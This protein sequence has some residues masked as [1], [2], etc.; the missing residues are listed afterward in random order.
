[1]SESREGGI[2]EG[3]GGA[4][5]KKIKSNEGITCKERGEGDGEGRPFMVPCVTSGFML[6]ARF[7]EGQRRGGEGGSSKRPQRQTTPRFKR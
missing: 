6:P 5:D 2:W 3:R 7:E 1:M 4:G